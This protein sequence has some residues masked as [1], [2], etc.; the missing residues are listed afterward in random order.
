M[1][2]L[3]LP[4]PNGYRIPLLLQA[5]QNAQLAVLVVH[6]F[7]SDKGG[8]TARRIQSELAAKGVGSCALDL[9]AH[10]E[11][12]VDGSALTVDNA[13]RDM[14]EAEAVL[15]RYMPKAQIGFFG[16]SFGAYLT[17]LYL[18]ARPHG[19]GLARPKAV[20]RCAALTMP[21]LLQDE[22]TPELRQQLASG[23][24]LLLAEYQPPL[25]L[26]QRFLDSL[27]AHDP[28]VLCRHD[29]AEVLLIHGTADQVAPIE[30]ARRFSRQMGY[31]LLEIE[32]ADHRFQG[33]GQMDE[34]V[35]A[36]LEHLCS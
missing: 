20:L 29:M 17:A 15:R 3:F 13:L 16:S 4:G 7:G 1:E 28:F 26:T 19:A 33:P 8:S 22:L 24:N 10:G 30:Q 12:P 11:S 18:A 9:P 36:A 6:G 31:P 21:K 14:A 2:K 25:L 23:Q 35:K 27:N 5:T 32:G 34:L